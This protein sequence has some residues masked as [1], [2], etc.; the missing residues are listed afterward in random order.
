[1]EEMYLDLIADVAIVLLLIF[2]GFILFSIENKVQKIKRT[3]ISRE[4]LEDVIRVETKEEFEYLN[5]KLNSLH[6]NLFELKRK[7]EN[8]EEVATESIEAIRYRICRLEEKPPMTTQILHMV[9]T[10]EEK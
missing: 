5:K 8:F 2:V 10:K 4:T 1:M 7:E 6:H 3:Y 9:E